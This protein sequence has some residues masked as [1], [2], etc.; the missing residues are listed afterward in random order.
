[1]RGSQAD[2]VRRPPDLTPRE[3]EQLRATGTDN[4]VLAP[5]LA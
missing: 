4:P 3:D 5:C 2:A 1:M